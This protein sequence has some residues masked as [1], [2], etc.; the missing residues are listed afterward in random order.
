MPTLGGVNSLRRVVLLGAFLL[1]GCAS[2]LLPE[3]GADADAGFKDFS[4]A[5]AAFLKIEPY[6]TTLAELRGLGFDIAANNVRQIPYPDLVARLAPNGIAFEHLDVG[7]R[8]CILARMDCRLYEYR[9]GRESRV[10]QGGVVLDLLNFKRITA[11]DSWRF[12]ALVALRDDVVLFNTYGGEPR[13]RRI[14]SEI[15]PLGP[16][17]SAGE[18]AAGHLLLR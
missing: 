11:V 14:E 15:N 8:Q 1:G 6:R 5:R 7:I 2:A 18:S 9:I 16:L 3:S 13:N 17:Q 4:E 12:D 10:R